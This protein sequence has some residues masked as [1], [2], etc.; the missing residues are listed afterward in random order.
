MPWSYLISLTVNIKAN[1]SCFC[2]FRWKAIFHLHAWKQ[3]IWS[4][5]F[6][7]YKDK[8]VNM[9]VVV[10]SRLIARTIKFMK[11][12]QSSLK[13][14]PWERNGMGL[15][16]KIWRNKI[17][18]FISRGERLHHCLWASCCRLNN[19]ITGMCLKQSIRCVFYLSLVWEA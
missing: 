5:N 1:S 15:I 19:T 14:K 11:Y 12:K 6:L 18:F 16:G 9:C 2:I 8:I 4:C 17:G 7:N 13:G 3:E 10:Y